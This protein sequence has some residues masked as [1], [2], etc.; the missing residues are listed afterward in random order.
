[1][2]SLVTLLTLSLLPLATPVF[3]QSPDQAAPAA[4]PTLACYAVAKGRAATPVRENYFTYSPIVGS[5]VAGKVFLGER[6]TGENKVLVYSPGVPDPIG[7]ARFTF[8][9]E[10][11]MSRCSGSRLYAPAY[12]DLLAWVSPPAGE[13]AAPK[14]PGSDYHSSWGCFQA[15]RALGLSDGTSLPARQPF[16]AVRGERDG[17]YTNELSVLD[18]ATGATVG[19]TTSRRVTQVP[20][21]RCEPGAAFTR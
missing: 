1:M 17:G 10:V 9:S 11:P 14:P 13:A 21:A 15:P 7:I 20:L 19:A 16:F 4:P 2:K 3:A 12:A 5:I 18:G 6:V 8:T